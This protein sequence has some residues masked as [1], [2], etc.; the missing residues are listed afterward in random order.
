MKCGNDPKIIARQMLKNRNRFLRRNIN[1][2]I[3]LVI[4]NFVSYDY[5]NDK[6]AKVD[7]DL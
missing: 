7:K 2:E 4:K 6:K 1:F 3:C 5:W